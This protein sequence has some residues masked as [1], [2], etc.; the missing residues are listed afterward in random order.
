MLP[1]Y[2][3]AI[4]IACAANYLL[5]W[6]VGIPVAA[7][8]TVGLLTFN[9]L[10]HPTIGS[11]PFIQFMWLAINVAIGITFA[12]SALSTIPEAPALPAEF[13]GGN[14]WQVAFVAV[15]LACYFGIHAFTGKSK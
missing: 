10:L 9:S 15:Q 14:W 4:T 1:A 6:N 5:P 3:L 2:I 8:I 12:L 11:E 7:V 13:G